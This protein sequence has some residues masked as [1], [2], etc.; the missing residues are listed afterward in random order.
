LTSEGLLL[1]C[2]ISLIVPHHPRSYL[3]TEPYYNLCH[4]SN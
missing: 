3:E 2:Q 4:D 1:S